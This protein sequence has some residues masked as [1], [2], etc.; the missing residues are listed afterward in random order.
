MIKI[1]YVNLGTEV[2][3]AKDINALFVRLDVVL[4]MNQKGYIADMSVAH[5]IKGELQV[6]Y[7]QMSERIYESRLRK[8]IEMFLHNV[9]LVIKLRCDGFIDVD[10]FRKAIRSE[11][12]DFDEVLRQSY[13]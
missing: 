9:K 2:E 13:R 1:E 12:S 5:A 4:T 8:Y 3:G 11:V 6:F 10:S 7:K